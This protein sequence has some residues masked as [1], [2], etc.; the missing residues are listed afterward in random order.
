M[1]CGHGRKAKWLLTILP[2]MILSGCGKEQAE[3]LAQVETKNIDPWV[4]L[5]NN[6]ISVNSAIR[7][8][9]SSAAGLLITLGVIGIVFSIMY[10]VIRL[11]FS[12]GNVRTKSEAKEEIIFKSVIGIML[13]SVSFWLGIIKLLSDLLL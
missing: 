13:F 2:A 3:E 12:G 4:Y 10:L 9:A 5:S 7:N 6:S 1:K 11:L 8:F